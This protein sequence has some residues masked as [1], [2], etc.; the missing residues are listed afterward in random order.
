MSETAE[1]VL[2]D[3]RLQRTRQKVD[4]PNRFTPVRRESATR[5]LKNQQLTQIPEAA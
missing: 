3:I 1:A 2:A 4:R 5:P